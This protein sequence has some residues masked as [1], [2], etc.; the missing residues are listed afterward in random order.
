MEACGEDCSKAWL[1]KGRER[2]SVVP[3]GSAPAVP[4]RRTR[5][6]THYLPANWLKDHVVHHQTSVPVSPLNSVPTLLRP[7]LAS[8]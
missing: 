7:M 6:R 4:T 8:L 2:G 3:A 5:A 1:A